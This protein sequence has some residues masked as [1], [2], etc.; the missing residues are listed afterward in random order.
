MEQETQEKQVKWTFDL[1]A[2]FV[3]LGTAYFL[4]IFQRQMLPV[5][6]DG[7]ISDYALTAAEY[8]ILGSAIFYPYALLQIPSGYFGDRVSPRRLICFS[9]MISAIGGFIF[10]SASGFSMLVVGRILT[11]IGTSFVYIPALAVLRRTFGDKRFGTVTGLFI[12]IAAVASMCTSTPLRIVSQY[13]SRDAIFYTVASISLI[14]S[15]SAWL[16]IKEDASLADRPRGIDFKAVINPGTTSIVMWFLV[17]NGV[18]ITFTSAWG[19]KYLTDAVSL[20]AIDASFVL[21]ANSLGGLF[22]NIIFGRVADK[23]GP[24]RTLGFC[25]MVRVA[26]WFALANCPPGS[27]WYVPAA[28]TLVAGCVNSGASTVGFIASKLFVGPENTGLVSGMNNT[29]TFIGSGIFTM[30]AAPV[31]A[32]AGASAPDQ[33]RL[34]FSLFGAMLFAAT[35]MVL[36]VNRR[37]LKDH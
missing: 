26:V 30:A 28:M 3:V 33:Y 20:D 16:L 15:I 29:G 9:S 23:F 24:L 37:H 4:S 25:A 14:T 11:S 27:P 18:S 8:A 22:G 2:T 36:F 35:A 17:L 31:M 5:L 1:I 6:S 34:L 10:A 7:L 13:V 21:F 12:T 19:F 32:M